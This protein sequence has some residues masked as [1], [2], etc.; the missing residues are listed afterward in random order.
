MF[1]LAL[2]FPLKPLKGLSVQRS[3]VLRI[4]MLAFL[5]GLAIIFYQVRSRLLLFPPP[6]FYVRIGHERG[7]LVS[8]SCWMLH[9]SALPRRE[10]GRSK[11]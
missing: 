10:D 7:N 4:V 11:G 1:M 2:E 3:I 5:S 8:N 9:T 6:V